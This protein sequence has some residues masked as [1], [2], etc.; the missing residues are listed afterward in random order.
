MTWIRLHLEVGV[1]PDWAPLDPRDPDKMMGGTERFALR[2]AAL[3]AARGHRV[4]LR[5]GGA[6]GSWRGVRFVQPEQVVGEVDLAIGV[7]SPLNADTD[8]RRRIAW[9]HAAQWP[10][11]GAWDAVVAVSGYHA[12]LLSARLPGIRV[13]QVPAGVELPAEPACG[14][15]RFLYASSPDRGLHRLLAMWP[16]L[17]RTFGKPLSIAYDLRAVIRRHGGRTDLLGQ[18]LRAIAPLVDQ[19]GVVVHGPLRLEALA[20]LRARS[21]ALLYPLDP[22]IPHSELLSLSVLECCA[23]GVPPV[24]APVDCFASEYGQ[25]ARM[26]EPERADYSAQAWVE[27]VGQVLDDGGWAA[28][29]RAFAASRSWEAFAERWE[30]LMREVSAAEGIATPANGGQSWIV[31]AQGITARGEAALAAHLARAAVEAGHQPRVFTDTEANARI[32]EGSWPV[33]LIGAGDLDRAIG[34]GC[35]RLVL[36][37]S[38]GC[39]ELLARLP[40]L[41]PGTPLATLEHTWPEWLPHLEGHEGI[42]LVLDT[43]PQEVFELG[44]EQEIFR[45]DDETRRRVR[46]VGPL[47]ATSSAGWP[48]RDPRRI[49]VHMSSRKAWHSI[50]AGRIFEALGELRTQHPLAVRCVKELEGMAIPDWVDVAEPLVPRDLHAAIEASDLVICHD[51]ADIV[52]S[53]LAAGAAVLAVSDGAAF[54]GGSGTGGDRWCQAHFLAD[55]LELAPGSLTAASYRRLIA[56]LLQQARPRPQG[57]GAARA[58]RLIQALAPLAPTRRASPPELRP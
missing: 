5:G 34:A 8:A 53:A 32:L 40:R 22:V 9:S 44:L 51:G 50:I 24:L 54:R 17:W 10:A 2:L 1:A 3:M 43:L 55:K 57:G 13:E 11:V 58:V 15:D 56:E 18:R 38:I 39:R 26:V 28:R 7:Q 29:A 6:T 42:S 21:L 30:R 46:C 36:S 12:G 37:S 45:L 33:E 49:L 16:E 41:A 19:P 23:A 52:G 25:V 35:D 4:S 48:A 31:I 14:G 47:P 27:A 20:A